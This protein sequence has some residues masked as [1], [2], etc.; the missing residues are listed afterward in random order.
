MQKRVEGWKK[1]RTA[2]SDDPE[3]L[4]WAAN[5]VQYVNYV[6]KVTTVRG[7]PKDRKA[8][9]VL[10]KKVPLLS[11]RFLPPSYLHIQKRSVTPNVLPTSAYLK[12]LHIVHPFYY[13]DLT[14]CPQ[15]DSENVLWDG[16]T[17]GGHREV[18]GVSREETALGYQLKCH[19]C[20]DSTERGSYCVAT[21]N[22]KFW[23]KKELWEVPRKCTYECENLYSSPVFY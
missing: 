15:C 21:T 10:R 22:A 14:K 20:R 6:H 9:P 19:V 12:P 5:V 11:P 23:E 7:G 4:T 16:W 13:P 2:Q 8:A 3:Q 17:T 18:H 1:H